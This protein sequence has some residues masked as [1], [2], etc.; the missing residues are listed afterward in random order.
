VVARVVE[1]VM[2][3]ALGFLAAT[4]IAL[5]IIPA[6]NARADRLARR[7]AEALFPLSISEL[8]AEKDHLRAEFAVMQRRIERRAEEALAVKHHAMDELGRRA[9]RIDQ[10]ETDVAERDAAI[11]DLQADLEETRSRLAATDEELSL[12]RAT[13]AAARETLSAVENAHRKTLDELASTRGE[14]ERTSTLLAGAKAE[15]AITQDRLEAREAEFADL[16]G[17]HTAALS[18]LDTKR[19]TVSDLETRLAMQT[20]RGDDFERALGDRRGELTDERRRLTDLANDLLAEQE[21]GIALESRI[22]ELEKELEAR[23]AG[24]SAQ[25]TRLQSLSADDDRLRT[26]LDGRDEAA[27]SGGREREAARA[28]IAAIETA[29]GPGGAA[30]ASELRALSGEVE[31]LRADKASLE[32][33]LGTA[34]EERNRLEREL[35][36]LRR[37]RGSTDEIKA[38]NAELRR[39]ITDLADS[40]VKAAGSDTSD[41]QARDA[42]GPIPDGRRKAAG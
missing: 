1:S 36:R 26:S 9:V 18:E 27:K 33:A 31:G 5:L 4:L 19:I 42:E 30:H 8:T 3:F 12:T 22:R 41:G 32:S 21:R 35:K 23:V 25:S 40:V 7:R 13:L 14:L 38:E 24:F 11:G 28:R 15:L 20:G 29:G 6:I 17:R 34:R 39:L 37:T 2:I 16:D 10:L